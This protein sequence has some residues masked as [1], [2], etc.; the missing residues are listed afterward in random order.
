MPP[1][2]GQQGPPGHHPGQNPHMQPGAGGPG[3]QPQMMFNPQQFA[4]MGGPQG[5]FMS[6]AP[7]AAGMMP[8]PGPAG[9]MQN[10][11]MP[12][13]VPNGQSKF[14]RPFRVEG[15]GCIFMSNWL[16][17][18]LPFEPPFQSFYQRTR[19]VM[20]LA[21]DC[22][23]VYPLSWAFPCCGR[24]RHAAKELHRETR[25]LHIKLRDVLALNHVSST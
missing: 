15:G 23:L 2:F 1:N 11:G 6:G 12:H 20:R 10:A 21:R 19:L 5:A 25:R 9:M 8:G 18:F 14:C 17:H 13:M 7:N 16:A 3:Q 22:L 24:W 4:A